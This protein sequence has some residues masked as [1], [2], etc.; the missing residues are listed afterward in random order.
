MIIIGHRGAAGYEPENTLRSFKK[1]IDMHVDMIEFDVHLCKSGEV[2]VIHDET[3]ERTTN[4]YG[5][6]ADSTFTQL[7]D[8]DAG[9]GEFIPTLEEVLDLANK[10]C[11]I[12]VELKGKGTAGP[13]A[14]ILKRY[15]RTGWSYEDF[16][17]SSFDHDLLREFYSISPEAKIAALLE[18]DLDYGIKNIPLHAVNS[19]ITNVTKEFVERAHKYRMKV[20]VWTVNN[21][22][23]YGRMLLYNVDGV[24]TD[25]PFL[26]V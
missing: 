22:E 25:Y 7:V 20:Y 16:L 14:D 5:F 4:A 26:H 13:V 3:L 24:F 15:T 12:N 8:I 11:K 10:Q 19:S 6:V 9:K 17:I 1:A 18:N 2:M 23:D 21:I